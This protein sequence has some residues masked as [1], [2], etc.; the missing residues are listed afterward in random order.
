LFRISQMDLD[1]GRVPLGKLAAPTLVQKVLEAFGESSLQVFGNPPSEQGQD[2]GDLGR[3]FGLTGKALL[4]EAW[5]GLRRGVLG[6]GESE[7]NTSTDT[8]PAG[9]FDVGLGS[10]LHSGHAVRLFTW[11]D[12]EVGATV[13]GSLVQG[14]D[15]LVCAEG[16]VQ[17]HGTFSTSWR[18]DED[19][20]LGF[21]GV[22]QSPELSARLGAVPWSADRGFDA[23]KWGLKTVLGF[24]H[25]KGWRFEVTASYLPGGGEAS[26]GVQLRVGSERKTGR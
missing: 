26:L 10:Q 18:L 17:A 6:A 23:G 5:D 13:G 22:L 25:V 1:T 19:W 11:G 21:A 3:A 24:A 12:L 2:L 20:T 15:C 16:T 4:K 8:S 14:S 7:G 9:A